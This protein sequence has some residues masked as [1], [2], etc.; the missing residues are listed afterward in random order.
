M[1]FNYLEQLA[2]ALRY[3]DAVIF[4]AVARAQE[5]GFDPANTLRGLVITDEDALSLAVKEPLSAIW[6]QDGGVPPFPA[7][8][9]SEASPLAAL[10]EIFNL[11]DLDLAIILVCFSV[12]IDQRYERLYAYLQDDVTQRRPTVNL[13]MNLLG[14]TV[15]ERFEVWERLDVQMP[16]RSLNLLDCVPDPTR[17]HS[18][19][20]THQVKLDRRT[21]AFLLGDATIDERIQQAAHLM[22]AN[23]KPI[24]DSRIATALAHFVS[25][26]P[27]LLLLYGEDDAAKAAEVSS[28]CASIKTPVMRVD[29]QKLANTEAP[30]AIIW[31][32]TL[33]EALFQ[34]AAL[35]LDHWDAILD[36]RS[37]PN[38]RIWHD[39]LHLN[40][41]V[42]ISAAHNW[43][44][45]DER[46][47][48][49]LLRLSYEL[50]SYS[51]RIHLWQQE[52]TE[53][54]AA[55]PVHDIALISNK[56][57]LTTNRIARAAQAA[58]DWAATHGRPLHA[59][60]LIQGAQAHA[61]L[62]LDKLAQHVQPRFSWNDLILPPEQTNQIRELI[63]RV[64]Y[65]SIVHTEWGFGAKGAPIR[66]VS[67]LF[68]GESG[69][70]KTL[71]AEVIA[72]ELGLIMYKIDL[73]AVVS[74]Y[75]GETE[76]NLKTIFDEAR[77]GNAILFFD[78]ADALFGKRSEVKDAHD[79]YANIEV[80][81][82]LQ[83]IENYD[84]VAIMATNLRQNLDDAFTRRLDF[85]IDFPFP[86]VEYRRQI[87][88]LHFP[89][90]APLS[91]DVDLMEIAERY[92]LSG[93]SIR[94]AALAAAF[95]AASE[96]SC[97][98]MQHIKRAIRREHQK[99]GRLLDA[100][101]D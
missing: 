79:R 101:R 58:A 22:P 23:S 45:L 14:G 72:H 28:F 43:E 96:N 75:I 66:R 35:L 11:T 21:V 87:W 31:G 99:M 49:R 18:T 41:M 63:D 8:L 57:R 89:S 93:G 56:F 53:V 51:E 84:G 30:L 2:A 65:A 78:E 19:F 59:D 38:E 94:N 80:A 29:L 27:P 40:R 88:E 95:L 62:R 77:A 64:S 37:R 34:G 1:N 36:E 33:R 97:I 10:G 24:Q 52:L 44:P 83:Q 81:Y 15:R 32:I 71:A 20:I 55:L 54:G 7:S 68:A 46:R 70:G 39:L 13:I 90:R 9:R 60:D 47:Q 91:A 69:T 5:A 50:P 67:A 6:G 3:M 16:L 82:L 76:K 100:V 48:R 86:D 26:Q 4:N 98:T 85:V 73:S 12:E 61:S 42:F 74:K 17:P 25:A 92:R